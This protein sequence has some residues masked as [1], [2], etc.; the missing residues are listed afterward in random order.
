MG[1]GGDR[2]DCTVG[3]K[4]IPIYREV[5]KTGNEWIKLNENPGKGQKLLLLLDSSSLPYNDLCYPEKLLYSY[6]VNSPG[7]V[8]LYPRV[9]MARIQ[10]K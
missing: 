2:T 4:I 10:V 9:R 8:N 5:Q 3:I 6:S 7:K 1:G